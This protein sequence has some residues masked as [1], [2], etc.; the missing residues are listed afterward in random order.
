[1]CIND[2]SPLEEMY[3][4]CNNIQCTFVEIIF[5]SY[6]VTNESLCILIDLNDKFVLH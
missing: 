4:L 1:M 6:I 2:E 5:I 3:I